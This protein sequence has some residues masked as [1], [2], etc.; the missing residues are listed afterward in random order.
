MLPK[1]LHWTAMQFELAV[2][3]VLEQWSPECGCPRPG[4][5]P[6]CE[7]CPCLPVFEYRVVTQIQSMAVGVTPTLPGI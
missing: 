1:L 2:Q 5:Q 4:Q 3:A 7:A 6:Q